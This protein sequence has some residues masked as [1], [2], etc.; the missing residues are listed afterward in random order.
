VY[1]TVDGEKKISNIVNRIEFSDDI[2]DKEALIQAL[3]YI[4]KDCKCMKK[5]PE[6]IKRLETVAENF[7]SEKVSSNDNYT[8]SYKNYY[9]EYLDDIKNQ[10]E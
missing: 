7:D 9:R 5:Y 1:L 3:F 6:L 2:R 8:E 4:N 10:M